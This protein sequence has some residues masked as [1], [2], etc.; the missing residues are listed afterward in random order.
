M[1]IIPKQIPF[2]GYQIKSIAVKESNAIALSTNGVV[3]TWGTNA[4]IASHSQGVTKYMSSYTP[5]IVDELY[6]H[7]DVISNVYCGERFFVATSVDSY[8]LLTWGQWC[9]Y[10]NSPIQRV[11]GMHLGLSRK[12]HDVSCT[13]KTTYCLL[14]SG[15]IYYWNNW[16]GNGDKLPTQIPCQINNIPF[17]RS[18]SSGNTH[19]AC[20]D[21]HGNV[22]VL[23][24]ITSPNIIN[25]PTPVLIGKS[26]ANTQYTHVKCGIDSLFVLANNQYLYCWGKN[27]SNKLSNTNHTVF[28]ELTKMDGEY[29]LDF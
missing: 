10:H 24:V 4:R 12:I 25:Q 21:V 11:S 1:Q 19:S 17:I 6:Q 8:N 15:V 22:Y 28:H 20:I 16:D 2:Y 5:V 13:D 9:H 18:I 26:D 14:T 3:F 29:S 7:K 23:G 27:T